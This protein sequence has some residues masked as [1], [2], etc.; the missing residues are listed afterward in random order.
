MGVFVLAQVCLI[1]LR[2]SGR[3][4]L[5]NHQRSCNASDDDQNTLHFPCAEPLVLSVTTCMTLSCAS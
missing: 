1:S 5:Q 2:E 3:T 4:T